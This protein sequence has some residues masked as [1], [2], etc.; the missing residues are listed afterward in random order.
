MKKL[1]LPPEDII[2][3]EFEVGCFHTGMTKYHFVAMETGSILNISKWMVP[4]TE[5]GLSHYETVEM[6]KKIGALKI[7]NWKSHYDN[8]DV[9]DG[10]Q[11][12]LII[13]YTGEKSREY[14]GSNAY[15]SK[16]DDLVSIFGYDFKD[17]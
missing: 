4:E 2:E 7:E 8:L 5:I 9:Q 15:P 14:G 3:V 10:T 6:Q 17:Y 1:A 12:T 11:W 13:T 16:W